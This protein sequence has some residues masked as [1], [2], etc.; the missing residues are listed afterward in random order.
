MKVSVVILD[1][2]G[3]IVESAG[4]KTE[5]YRRLVEPFGRKVDEF[6]AYHVAHSG[7][8]RYEKIRHYFEVMLGEKISEDRLEELAA[9]FSSLVK[10]AVI[11]AP[12]VPGAIEFLEWAAPRAAL[13]LLS[14]TPHDE[15]TEIVTARNLARHFRSVSGYPATKAETIGRIALGEKRAPRECLYVGDAPSDQEAAGEAGVRFIARL[16]PDNEDHFSRWDGEKV[17][18]LVGLKTRLAELGWLL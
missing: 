3:V 14:G 16:T 9:K 5:A 6:I 1:F 2:D 10:E 13:H 8:S 12:V 11:A 17:E 18:D 15:L 7:L 4:L